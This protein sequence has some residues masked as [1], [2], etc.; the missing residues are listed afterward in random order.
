MN[1]Q[2]ETPAAPAGPGRRRRGVAIPGAPALGR[3]TSGC[4]GS[5][6]SGSGAPDTANP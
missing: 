4:T 5:D 3:A 1:Q 2:L 6:A